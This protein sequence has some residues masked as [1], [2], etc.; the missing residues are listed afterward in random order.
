MTAGRFVPPADGATWAVREKLGAV[1]AALVELLAERF[2]LVGQLWAHKAAVGL[3]FEDRER[4]RAML[5]KIRADAA[6]TGLPPEFAEALFR[7]VIVHG[8]RHA[9]RG[10]P[11]S[12]RSV[13]RAP[14]SASTPPR[15]PPT[16]GSR[17]PAFPR[18][19][20][21]PEG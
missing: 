14:K 16:K 20:S 13:R 19:G 4:E 2:R 10:S 8:K 17:I 18:P 11:G 9:L 7:A 3:P 15:R 1:D 5:R 21:G 6:R 12:R